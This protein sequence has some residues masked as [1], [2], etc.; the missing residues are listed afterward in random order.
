MYLNLCTETAFV[1]R[2]V[3]RET[4]PG[5]GSGA[6]TGV[7]NNTRIHTTHQQMSGAPTSAALFICFGGAA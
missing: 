5:K 3:M 2:N 4:A 1:I 7:K 6:R